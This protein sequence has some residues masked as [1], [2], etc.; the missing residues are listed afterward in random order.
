M[1]G[2]HWIETVDEVQQFMLLWTMIRGVQLS[3]TPDEITWRLTQNGQYWTSSAYAAQFFGS[4][5]DYNWSSLSKTRIENKC[6][7]WLILQNRLKTAGRIIKNGGNANPICQ[8]CYTHNETH[9]HLPI[10]CPFSQSVWQGLKEWLG[11]ELLP[12]PAQRYRRFKTWWN[13]M[14]SSRGPGRATTKDRATKFIYAA[15]NIWKERCRCLFNNKALTASQLQQL[16]REDVALWQRACG[17]AP[18]TLNPSPVLGSG[19]NIVV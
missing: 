14:L 15:W 7:A 11:A 10:S 13:R 19:D 2:L 17:G 6:K 3:D 16:T 12:L 1:R 5:L 8:L 4:F 18:S 9:S